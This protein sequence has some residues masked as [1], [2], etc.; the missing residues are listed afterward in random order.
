M[1]AAFAVSRPTTTFSSSLRVSVPQCWIMLF[2]RYAGYDHLGLGSGLFT[3]QEQPI[4]IPLRQWEVNE[5]LRGCLPDARKIPS[6]NS[7]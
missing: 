5:L 2:L 1:L 6:T 3:S 4:N 7:G